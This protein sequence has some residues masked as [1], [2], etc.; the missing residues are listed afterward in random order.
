MVV[1]SRLVWKA[2]AR[3][4]G[5]NTAEAT[6]RNKSPRVS[7]TVILPKE[8]PRVQIKSQEKEFVVDDFVPR[9][10]EL[11]GAGLGKISVSYFWT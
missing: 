10:G 3:P 1:D 9:Q 4:Q 11:G 2:H 6:N 8:I 7:F 5:A